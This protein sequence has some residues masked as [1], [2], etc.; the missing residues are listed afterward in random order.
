MAHPVPV[1]ADFVSN[2]LPA[3]SNALKEPVHLVAL[4]LLVVLVYEVGRILTE[5]WRRVV[6]GARPLEQ[7]AVDALARP[8]DAPAL[9]RQAPGPVAERAVL[10]LAEAAAGSANRAPAGADEAGAGTAGPAA[11]GSVEAGS[12]GYETALAQ[13]ELQVQRRLDRTRM[14]VRAGPAV[15][16]MGTLIPLAPGLAELGKGNYEQLATDLRVAFAATVIGLLVGTVAFVLTL[17]RTRIYTEDLAALERAV[18]R[19]DPQLPPLHRVAESVGE[20]QA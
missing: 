7:I 8:G 1:A 10:A 4:L 2:T 15:G 16:L 20:H 9:A 19:H 6:P 14:L 17:I 12:A 13:Y 5:G 3:F 18:A 11:A